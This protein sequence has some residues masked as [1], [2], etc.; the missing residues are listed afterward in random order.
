MKLTPEE[1]VMKAKIQLQTTNPFFSSVLMY[2]PISV[3]KD[4]PSMCVDVDGNIGYNPEW[5]DELPV[6]EITG[7]FC[8]EVLHAVLFHLQRLG[9]KN[10]KVFNISN[11]LVVNDMLVANNFLLPKQGMI[12]DYNHTYTF[13]L[14]KI[15]YELKNIN[16]KTSEQVYYEIIGLFKDKEPDGDEGFDK[17]IYGDKKSV[18][19]QEKGKEKWREIIS[20]ATTYAKKVGQL[21][22]GMERYIDD[23]LGGKINWKNKLYRYITNTIMSDY[24][25]SRPH[26]KSQA[27]GVYLPQ[28]TREGIDIVAHIDTSGSISQEELTEFVSEL[29]SLS[30][31]FNALN[32]TLIMCDA[33]V[34]AVYEINQSNRETLLNLK[35]AGG[36]GTSHYPVV[37]WVKKN[38]PNCRVLITL[39]DGWSDIPECFPDLP[40][41]KLIVMTERNRN[42]NLEEYGEVIEI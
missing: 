15:G 39:T 12:P 3:K 10:H 33:D 2:M 38:K 20:N 35:K 30:N 17:H 42:T 23:I 37:E 19:E 34:D 41:D 24:S 25:W 31:S 28:V 16:E 21:P 18:A 29:V 26:K 22:A 13:K 7:V 1:K 27:L 9:N 14:P 11:D 6:R 36:G 4:I 32:M 5:I 40:C 8:H